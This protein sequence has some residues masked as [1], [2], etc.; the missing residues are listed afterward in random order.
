[1]T[2]NAQRL[3][4][5]NVYS[6]SLSR[7]CSELNCRETDIDSSNK[8]EIDF[9]TLMNS[10]CIT[11]T[12]LKDIW[13]QANHLVSTPS[14]ISLVPGQGD[15]SNNRIVASITGGEPHYVTEKKSRFSCD[16]K[17]PRFNTYKICQHVLAA[18]HSC[19]MLRSFCDWWKSL[20]SSTN[21]DSLATVDI[22]KG[23]GQKGGVPKKERRILLVKPIQKFFVRRVLLMVIFLV[24]VNHVNLMSTHWEMMQLMWLIVLPKIPVPLASTSIS[25]YGSINQSFNPHFSHNCT[26][27]LWMMNHISQTGTAHQNFFLSACHSLLLI[28]FRCIF[29]RM[30][31]SHST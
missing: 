31:S 1:M 20:K 30:E 11:T 10:Y 28:V 3:H 17:C 16:G 24:V 7:P 13:A 27:V 25:N 2:L 14:F 12:T 29:R 22:P 19:G 21:V 4:L 8:L 9:C 26:Q 6:E 18:A 15:S 23:A 5:S